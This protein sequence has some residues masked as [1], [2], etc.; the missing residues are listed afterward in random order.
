MSEI[1][2]DIIAAVKEIKSAIVRVQARVAADANAEMPALYFGV[3]RYVSHKTKS[4]K[5]GS[6]VIDAISVRLQK[7]MLG[8]RGFSDRNIRKMR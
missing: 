3:G 7:E 4:E 2:T 8:L 6:G 1:S 5:W